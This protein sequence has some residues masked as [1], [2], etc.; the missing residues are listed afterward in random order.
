MQKA[1]NDAAITVS[2]CRGLDSFDQTDLEALYRTYNSKNGRVSVE[3]LSSLSDSKSEVIRSQYSKTY[4]SN[5]LSYI[6][7]DLMKDVER[8]PMCSLLPVTDLDHFW[9]SS[10][11]GQLAVC[12]LN[13]VPTCGICN[14]KKSDDDADGFIHA[15]Y[16]HFPIGVVF[17]KA[18][19]KILRGYVVPVFSIDGSGIADPTLERRL[20]NQIDKI[21]LKA[22]L[23]AATKEYLRELFQETTFS[24]DKVMKAFLSKT[25]KKLIK[26]KGI[27]DWR[28][29]LIRGIR[30]CPGMSITVVQNYRKSSKRLKDGRV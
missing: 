14:K 24:T 27:N 3:D 21:N 11:F 22:R 29:A 9:C 30:A 7:T 2:H 6:R 15:Y 10:H 12:R 25:E 19:C 20:N 18:D 26:H 16:Q 8:C 17:L 23:R 1:L 13:L 28:T 4:G 5:Q